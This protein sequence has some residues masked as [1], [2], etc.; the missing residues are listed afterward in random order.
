MKWKP[1]YKRSI[2]YFLRSM[3]NRQIEAEREWDWIP[4]TGP[5]PDYKHHPKRY[6]KG[7][8]NMIGYKTRKACQV[9]CNRYNDGSAFRV[10]AST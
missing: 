5:A 2:L 9:G 10:G 1:P 8:Q 3:L 6:P 7:S 4:T